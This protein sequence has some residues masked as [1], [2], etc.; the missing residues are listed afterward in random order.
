MEGVNEDSR[1]NRRKRPTLRRATRS[2]VD[3]SMQENL[4]FGPLIGVL[5]SEKLITLLG[6]VFVYW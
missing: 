6:S 4:E 2:D 5:Y 3:C 1:Q